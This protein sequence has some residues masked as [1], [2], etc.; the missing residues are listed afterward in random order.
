MT[1]LFVQAVSNSSS[2]WFIN[3]TE[4][5]QARNGPCIFGC[6]ALRVVK[7]GRH[8]HYSIRDGLQEGND[9]SCNSS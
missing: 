5:V 6:L 9:P 2:S 3:D 1:Y 4:D 7:V 8:G